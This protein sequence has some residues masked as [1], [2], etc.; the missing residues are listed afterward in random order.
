MIN[1]WFSEATPLVNGPYQIHRS[2][3]D[4]TEQQIRHTAGMQMR[5]DLR[6]G[7]P[8]ANEIAIED[9]NLKARFFPNRPF[10][11]CLTSD[12]LSLLFRADRILDWP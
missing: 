9:W 11:F 1:R 8:L 4:R 3:R 12:I 7:F 6:E 10:Q 5:S 2:Q